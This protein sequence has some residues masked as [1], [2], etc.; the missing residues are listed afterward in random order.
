[1]PST[2]MYVRRITRGGS[3]GQVVR[4]TT[5]G[6]LHTV[7][8]DDDG[9]GVIVWQGRGINST[10]T[11][12]ARRISRWGGLGPTSLLVAGI[13]RYPT[14]AVSPTG[15]AIVAWERGFQ[16]DQRIQVSVGP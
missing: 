6:R 7:R 12:R 8:V 4:V 1:F 10:P 2:Y 16:A 9:D 15:R 11:V 5:Y 14:M 3:V 13:G